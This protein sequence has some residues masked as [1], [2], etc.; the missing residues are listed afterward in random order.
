M[1]SLVQLFVVL[2]L[3]V[4]VVAGCSKKE[5]PVAAAPVAAPAPVAP[6]PVKEEAGGWTPPPADA[7]PAAPAVEAPVA[8]PAEA[9]AAAK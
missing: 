5:E 1:K 7:V 2:S 6:A 8:A 3:G 4:A 9:P